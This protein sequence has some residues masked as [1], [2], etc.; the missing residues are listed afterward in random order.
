MEEIVKP[1]SCPFCQSEM[2][3]LDI[4]ELLPNVTQNDGY[5]DIKEVKLKSGV[6][7]IDIIKCSCCGF[8][9]LFDASTR[10]RY[11][12]SVQAQELGFYDESEESDKID[13]KELKLERPIDP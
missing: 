2:E 9:A 13:L 10:A 3:E 7:D 8:I 5:I 6:N 11:E 4:L 1:L 12:I